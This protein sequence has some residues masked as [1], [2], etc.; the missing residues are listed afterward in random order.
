MNQIYRTSLQTG[1]RTRSE[2]TQTE[3]AVL[4]ESKIVNVE[5]TRRVSAV[6]N[7]PKYFFAAPLHEHYH[8]DGN[9]VEEHQKETLEVNRTTRQKAQLQ[10]RRVKVMTQSADLITQHVMEHMTMTTMTSR[11]SVFNMFQVVKCDSSSRDSQALRHYHSAPSSIF[12]SRIKFDIGV[13]FVWV[14]TSS[15]HVPVLFQSSS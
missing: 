13:N 2:R 1:D 10:R 4:C 9:R 3:R 5:V 12:H 15:H 6:H 8:A 14:C 7:S 11:E